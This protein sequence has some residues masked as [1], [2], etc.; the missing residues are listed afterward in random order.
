MK[1]ADYLYENSMTP[2]LLRR[3]LGVTNRSTVWR[4]LAGE[5]I[6]QPEMMLKI[7]RLTDGRVTL[8]DF[9]DPTPPRCA[10]VVV[11]ER[12]RKKWVLPWS[13]GWRDPRRPKEPPRSDRLSEP[14][15]QGLRSLGGRAWYTP[16]GVFLLDGRK[17]SLKRLM[18]AANEARAARGEPRIPY[19]GVWPPEGGGA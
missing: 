15:L 3:K 4:W 10:N 18:E 9:L 17:V 13:P 8:S 5:R 19:P 16:R 11:D 2:G 7:E 14:V 6:P 12:G 1:L